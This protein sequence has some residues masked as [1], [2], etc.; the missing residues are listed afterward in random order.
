MKTL[1]PLVSFVLIRP[2]CSNIKISSFSRW[3]VDMDSIDISE[4]NQTNQEKLNAQALNQLLQSLI[5]A[6]GGIKR[7]AG[8][9]FETLTKDFLRND[10]T[11]K[12]SLIHI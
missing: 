12:L 5:D 8:T 10:A 3:N 9:R 1:T 7:D 2:M 11:Y 4:L 6:S